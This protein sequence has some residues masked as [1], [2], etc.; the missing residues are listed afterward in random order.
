MDP[1]KVKK[2]QTYKLRRR[3]GGLRRKPNCE[4]LEDE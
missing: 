2:Y 1:K 3:N 4:V